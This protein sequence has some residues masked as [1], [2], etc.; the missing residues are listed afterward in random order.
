MTGRGVD[1]EGVDVERI[2]VEGV[3]FLGGW[4]ANVVELGDG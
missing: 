3:D 4:A 2:D 1:V